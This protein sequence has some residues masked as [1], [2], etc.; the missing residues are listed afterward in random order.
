MLPLKGSFSILRRNFQRKKLIFYQILPFLVTFY[1]D[2]YPRKLNSE[3]KSEGGGSIGR[4]V[5]LETLRY[6]PTLFTAAK[7]SYSK[8]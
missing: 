7:V 2:Q 3:N 5:P 4:V 6:T 8:S 1:L